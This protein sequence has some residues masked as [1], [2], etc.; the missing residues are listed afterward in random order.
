MVQPHGKRDFTI[1]VEVIGFADVLD[2]SAVCR[3]A[4]AKS[5]YYIICSLARV[6]VR[7][8]DPLVKNIGGGNRIRTG[9]P[10][11]ARQV[12]YQLSYTP[13]CYKPY[14]VLYMTKRERLA[15]S[16]LKALRLLHSKCSD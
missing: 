10:L 12:L 16:Q 6:P 3:Q 4:D 15:I 2:C 5:P 13:V 8:R 7:I 11:L 14:A 1:L 9:D